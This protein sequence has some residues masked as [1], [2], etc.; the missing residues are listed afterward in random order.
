MIFYGMSCMKLFF[1]YKKC[2]TSG[3]KL[4][5]LSWFWLVFGLSR[6]DQNKNLKKNTLG[7]FSGKSLKCMFCPKK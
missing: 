4:L 2:V 7:C 5:R 1:K 3:G 6:L